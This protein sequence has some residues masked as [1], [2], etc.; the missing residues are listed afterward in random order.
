MLAF[1]FLQGVYPRACGGTHVEPLP[2]VQVGV[3][4]RACGGT[5]SALDSLVHYGG[6]SPRLRGNVFVVLLLELL[7]GSIP[8]LAG[9]RRTALFA[10]VIMRVYPRACG[11][12][13]RAR[14]WRA[15]ISGLSPRL[16]GNGHVRRG[17]C[18]LR[19]SIPALAGE[20][21]AQQSRTGGVRVYPRACGGTVCAAIHTSNEKGLSPRLRGNGFGGAI[22]GAFGRSIP[23]LAGERNAHAA[24]GRRFR[25]YPRACGGTGTSG[26]GGVSCAGL[27]PRLRGNGMPSSRAQ[28]ASGSIPALAG[29]RFAR[30]FT[31]AT[32]RVYPRACGG[33]V[34][35]GRSGVRSVGLS[36]RLRGNGMPGPQPVRRMGSIPALAG[37]RSTWPEVQSPTGVYPRACGGTPDFR[38]MNSSPQLDFVHYEGKQS[39]YSS[40]LI[41]RD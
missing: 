6:L 34:L 26:A 32:K 39:A 4:P 27:S 41:K 35:G 24:G 8:A 2:C 13:K 15:Q 9:E 1:S 12:T 17:R 25:V 18:L 38:H 23:A 37:E 7:V 20:R 19:G 30:Q 5:R 29:E 36:P 10:S 11:G 3:Y 21:N 33:T 22:R 31:L 14:R 28:A 40:R 16:R